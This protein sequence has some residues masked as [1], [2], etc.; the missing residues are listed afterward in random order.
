VGVRVYTSYQF[1]ACPVKTSRLGVYSTLLA[2]THNSYKVI[3]CGY[4]SSLI[5][6]VVVY[7]YN[8]KRLQ[9]LLFNQLQAPTKI[10]LFV[11]SRYD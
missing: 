1:T 5:R 2:L 9:C 7:N 4:G 6:R 8:L 3:F 11:I 10:A